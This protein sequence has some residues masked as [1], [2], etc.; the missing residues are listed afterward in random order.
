[1]TALLLLAAVATGC[2]AVDDAKLASMESLAED[3]YRITDA[4]SNEGTSDPES[5]NVQPVSYS[6]SDS[7]PVIHTLEAGEDLDAIMADSAGVVLLD[8]YADWCGPCRKQSRELHAIESFAQEA[9]GQVVKIDVD[10]HDKI[11]K[12]YGVASLPTLLVIKDGQIL[13]RKLGLTSRNELKAML[14]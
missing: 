14:R 11:A 9:Q 13:Q 2:K 10:E 12:Q 8:F 5:A 7:M 6:I 1:M 3:A 4:T